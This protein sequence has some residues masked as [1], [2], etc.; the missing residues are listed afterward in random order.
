M[1]KIAV[2]L[3]MGA[4]IVAISA[5]DASA[6]RYLGGTYTYT[7]V[8]ENGEQSPWNNTDS[9]GGVNT[10]ATGA[11]GD[12]AVT[13]VATNQT[14]VANP[15]QVSF[16]DVP[17]DKSIPGKTA[18]WWGDMPSNNR[19][20]LVLMDLGQQVQIDA[21]AGVFNLRHNGMNLTWFRIYGSN[22]QSTWDSII[23]EEPNPNSGLKYTGIYV[24]P[25]TVPIGLFR[26]PTTGLYTDDIVTYRYL[27]IAL[28]TV[29]NGYSATGL[30]E[31]VIDAV[32]EPATIL[33]LV[34]GGL[35][36]LLRRKS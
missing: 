28:S 12:G 21:I 19:I 3:L 31:F 10:Y 26:N 15:N 22:D 16:A 34:G 27:K 35:F 30:A 25:S 32:P 24:R 29:D 23:Q 14:S 7:N 13:L 18:V 5:G 11:L 9:P 17:G 4:A 1:R 2:L 36:G 33:M 8:T 6:Y 20:E